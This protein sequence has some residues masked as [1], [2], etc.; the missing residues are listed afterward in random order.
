MSLAVLS[1]G[2]AW[3]GVTLCLGAAGGLAVAAFCLSSIVFGGPA[4]AG[5]LCSIIYI[6]E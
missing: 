2:G 3:L 1:L 6:F 4:Y 5:L